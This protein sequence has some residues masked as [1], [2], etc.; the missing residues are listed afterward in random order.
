MRQA[1][2]AA[3]WMARRRNAA[4]AVSRRNRSDG[5]GSDRV[6]CR[7]SKWIAI[8]SAIN[9]NATSATGLIH[10]IDIRIF[11]PGR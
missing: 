4:S 6:C 8:G 11:C 10:V 1:N 3:S 9:A 7:T 2:S 5:Y